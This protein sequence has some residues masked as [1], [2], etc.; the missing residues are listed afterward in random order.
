MIEYIN[1]A[2]LDLQDMKNLV[3]IQ[4]RLACITYSLVASKLYMTTAFESQL[5]STPE[6]ITITS[7]K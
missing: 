2:L 5:N 7:F 6:N 1:S 3:V 4:M